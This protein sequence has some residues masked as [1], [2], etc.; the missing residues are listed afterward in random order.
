MVLGWSVMVAPLVLECGGGVLGCGIHRDG[1]G[2][3]EVVLD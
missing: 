2:L 1:V 3:K